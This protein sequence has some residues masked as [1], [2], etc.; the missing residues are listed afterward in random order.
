MLEEDDFHAAA[1]VIID[2]AKAGHFTAAKFVVD[3]VDPKPRGRPITLDVAP[4]ATLL[5]RYAALTRAMLTGEISPQEAHAVARVLE[6]E[7]TLQRS[8]GAA[9]R[10]PVAAPK[11]A[12][13][14]APD[15]HPACKPPLAAAP[16][17]QP[18]WRGGVSQAALMRKSPASRL[19]P[20]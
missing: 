16:A 5:Q 11:P 15:L 1:R 6:R 12:A 17:P 8:E 18:D 10:A 19:H 13:R 20:A 3:H 9:A 7:A 4:D 14:P 2:K